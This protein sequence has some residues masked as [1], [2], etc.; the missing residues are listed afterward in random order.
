M[1]EI[2]FNIPEDGE[3]PITNAFEIHKELL[4]MPADLYVD[5]FHLMKSKIESNAYL[6]QNANLAAL[7]ATAC[8]STRQSL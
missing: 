1:K 5:L 2:K 7:S 3:K 4:K 6:Y 8:C